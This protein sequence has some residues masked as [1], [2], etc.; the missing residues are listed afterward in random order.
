MPIWLA[1]LIAVAAITA[2]YFSCVRPTLR[3]HRATTG[4]S[5]QDTEL[6]RK[7]AEL[8]EDLRAL[9]AQATLDSGRAR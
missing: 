5:A 7:V 2:T 1:A 3:G 9:R 8:R 6:D 4:N